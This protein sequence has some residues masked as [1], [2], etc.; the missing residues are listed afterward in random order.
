MK[1]S[2]TVELSLVFPV[3]LM[4]LIV[5]MQLGLYFTYRI[6]TL[7][8]IN[9]SLT[10]CS[11]A[12]QERKTMD[13]AAQL[14]EEYLYDTLSFLPIE[15]QET[16]CETDTGWLKEEYTIGVTARYSF[17]FDMSWS[18]VEKSCVMNPVSFRN[19]LDFIWEKGKQYLVRFQNES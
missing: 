18:A 15:I 19:Q 3:I 10:V 5:F 12:R 11:R 17:L 2:F 9:Q 4:I 1:G 16:W 6:Y 8:T 7:C 14:G 13:E